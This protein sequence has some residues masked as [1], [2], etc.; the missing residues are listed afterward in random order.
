[1]RRRQSGDLIQNRLDR[2]LTHPL[3]VVRGAPT[4]LKTRL[5]LRHT[6]DLCSVAVQI[7]SGIPF[8]PEVATRYLKIRLATSADLHQ[9]YH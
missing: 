7:M 2:P 6:K 8:Q 1:M 9:V 4:P 5:K 3:P